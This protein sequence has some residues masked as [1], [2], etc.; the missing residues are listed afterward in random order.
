MASEILLKVKRTIGISHN[1]KDDDILDDI[2]ACLADLRA[3]GI[4][5]PQETDSLVLRAIK[6][7]CKGHYTEDPAKSAQYLERYD[8]LKGAL[9]STTG[10]G[11][12]TE[13]AADE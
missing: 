8:A 2:E 10:Y 6:L 5:D 4:L 1:K 12:A 3:C 13:D 11:F 7:Y 9:Q